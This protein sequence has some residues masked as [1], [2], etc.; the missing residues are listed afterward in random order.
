M[1]NM[2]NYLKLR[3]EELKKRGAKG[4]T[5]MEMLIVVAIIAVLIA[6]A[7]PVFTSQLE[8]AR[9]A[10]SVANIRS[11]YAE[12]QTAYITKDKVSTHNAVYDETNK[13]VTVKKVR[14][15]SNQKNNWSN[16]AEKLP[17]Y[18]VLGGTDTTDHG[19][20]GVANDYDVVFTYNAD[21]A[22]TNVEIKSAS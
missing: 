12:A 9:D 5:L 13:T 15:E 16:Q 4:F 7:I 3:K 18:S 14:I 8:N 21:G 11:A 6:I 20:T 10:T 22:I 1:W 2:K 19:D 17:F